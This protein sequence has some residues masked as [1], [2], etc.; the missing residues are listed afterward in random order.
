LILENSEVRRRERIV[1]VD[2]KGTCVSGLLVPR[3]RKGRL[4]GWKVEIYKPRIPEGIVTVDSRR[5][6]VVISWTPGEIPQEKMKVIES[7]EGRTHGGYPDR[8]LRRTSVCISSTPK[9]CHTEESTD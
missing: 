9:V 1:I 2:P 3:K 8:K 7:P 6:C 4:K 5:P